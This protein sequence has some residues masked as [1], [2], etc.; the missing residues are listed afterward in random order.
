MLLNDMQRRF[1]ET[2][3]DHPDVVANPPEDLYAVFDEGDIA[4]SNRLKVYRNNIVG[5]LTDV[6]I[7]SFPAIEKLVGKEFMEGMARSFILAHPPSQGCLNQYGSGFAE[8]IEAFEPAKGLPYLPDIAR[9]EIALNDAY[10]ASDDIAL[11]ENALAQIAPEDL[12]EITLKP[13]SSVYLLQSNYPIHDIR[14]FALSEDQSDA[15]DI[16]SGPAYLMVYRPKLDTEIIILEH[17]EFEILS[18]FQAGE[19]LGQ[20]VETIMS[21]SPDFNFQSFLQ[22][23]I[24]LETFTSL[25]ANA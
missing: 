9:L 4:L 13:R 25:D 19:A 8:F 17:A 16:D 7:A 22:K 5:S 24:F 14:D 18:L 11:S 23:H 10:Y 1:K 20:A 6:M 2:I 12:S 21:K 3:L 15:P